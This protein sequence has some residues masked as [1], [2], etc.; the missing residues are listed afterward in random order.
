MDYQPKKHHPIPI[1]KPVRCVLILQE[2]G[3]RKSS[4]A[5]KLSN[6][7]THIQVGYSSFREE[8]SC[9]AHSR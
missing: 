1:Y 8:L 7:I 3:T 5:A 9:P 6:F 4:K 2:L